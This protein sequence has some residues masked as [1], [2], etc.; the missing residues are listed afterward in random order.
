MA[1]TNIAI[2]NSALIKLGTST[3]LSF[4]D[5]TKE[6]N[7]CNLRFEE[8]RDI[9]LRLH[10]WNCAITRVQLAP[11]VTEPAFGFTVEFQLPTDL[12]RVLYVDPI[13]NDIDYRIEGRK[14]LAD[15]TTIDL[16]YVKKV[17][18]PTE[19]DVLMAEALATYLAYDISYSLT[20][21]AEM[22]TRMWDSFI[23]ILASARSADAKE[24][25]ARELQ[26]DLWIQSRVASTSPLRSN[27]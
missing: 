2:A 8:C 25:P 12:L 11:L 22:Q 24:E 4:T 3:I 10:P 16:V 6:A 26:A 19:M 15:V 7:L 21:S 9:V 5:G 1:T 14:L 17:T 23:K 18:D 27:R 13:E 20:Q